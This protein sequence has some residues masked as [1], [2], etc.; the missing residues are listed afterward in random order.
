MSSSGGGTIIIQSKTKAGAKYR[1]RVELTATDLA[2]IIA[3]LP[4]GALKD[5]L[6]DLLDD[7]P[8]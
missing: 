5:D 4:A 1:H 7:M 6:Q 2:A 8:D 3:A